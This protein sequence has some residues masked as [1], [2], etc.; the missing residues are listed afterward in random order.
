[1]NAYAAPTTGPAADDSVDPREAVPP[2]VVRAGGFMLGASG[3][4]M[5]GAGLQLFVF[6]YLTLM[7]E[8]AAGLQMVMG[9]AAIAVAPWLVKGRGWAALIGTP[10]AAAMALFAVSWT[11]FSLVQTLFSPLMLL[12]VMVACLTVLVVPF[13]IMPSLRVSRARKA[14]YS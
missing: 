11:V 1:M 9:I 3:F 12:E 13:T 14:L 2:L 8:V 7:Y 6:F 10:L 4:F 5:A